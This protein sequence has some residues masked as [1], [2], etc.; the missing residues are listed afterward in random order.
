MAHT[1]GYDEPVSAE[2]VEI[3]KTGLKLQ[4]KDAIPVGSL[5]TI[6]MPHMTLM[7]EVRHCSQQSDQLYIAGIQTYDVKS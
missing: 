3:S 2:V 1:D 7:G 4:V 5:L 6:A